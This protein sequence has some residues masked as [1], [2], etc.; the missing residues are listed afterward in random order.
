MLDY[1]YKL[2]GQNSYTS[3]DIA[4]SNIATEITK[5]KLN[6]LYSNEFVFLYSII[7]KYDGTLISLANGDT[8]VDL[9]NIQDVNS[10]YTDSEIN[11]LITESI[12]GYINL[13]SARE[14]AK[15]RRLNQTRQ[16]LF[17]VNPTDPKC[18]IVSADDYNMI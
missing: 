13:F 6:G 8:H 7:V 18:R 11:D 16:F 1:V 12:S 14:L 10:G 4:R 2:V 9:R 17:N 15:E 5:L 3:R